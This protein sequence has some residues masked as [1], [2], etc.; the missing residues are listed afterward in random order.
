MNNRLESPARSAP[1]RVHSITLRCP[2]IG[3]FGLLGLSMALVDYC[4]ERGIAPRVAI[5]N[6][7]YVD[8]TSPD[9]F[10]A[11]F[12]NPALPRGLRGLA[13]GALGRRARLDTLAQKVVF[14]EDRAF[15][16]WGLERIAGL[17]FDRTVELARRYVRPNA[18]VLADVDGVV[19]S[20]FEG[21]ALGL[22]FRGTDKSNEAPRVPLEFV[23]RTV[24]N[25]MEDR[26]HLRTVFLA[27]DESAFADELR[28]ALPGVA[29]VERDDAFRSADG[30][31]VHKKNTTSGHAR[32]MDAVANCLLLSRCEI[33]VRTCSLLS[34]WAP[35]F[36]P[37]MDV[38]CLNV[39][40]PQGRYFPEQIVAARSL[41][42]YLP[43]GKPLEGTAE[44]MRKS[45]EQYR[46][47]WTDVYRAAGYDGPPKRLFPDG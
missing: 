19:Q 26:P 6:P 41:S 7:N 32:G 30:K 8:E 14:P 1:L 16:A 22:H 23:V 37:A 44:E 5:T 9:A 21:P 13:A 31:P 36:N 3:Y 12:D 20:Q 43:E 34:A 25:V 33:V 10:A 35:I 27:T 40:H 45:A 4:D 38:V 46:G 47:Y 29:I 28:R 17:S 2:A 18:A 42:G 24:R 15:G 11:Y 39:P